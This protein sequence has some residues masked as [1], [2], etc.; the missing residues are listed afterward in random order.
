MTTAPAPELS[1]ATRLC[2]R[3]ATLI[4][5][6]PDSSSWRH[7]IVG[8]DHAPDPTGI[9]VGNRAA[10]RPEPVKVAPPAPDIQPLGVERDRAIDTAAELGLWTESE[11]R[12]GYGK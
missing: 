11:K 12:E 5:Y 4:R 10:A 6:W 8:F 3:C 2:G 9:Y 1:T 7:V